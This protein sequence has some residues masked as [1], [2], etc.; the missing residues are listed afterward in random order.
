MMFTPKE[1]QLLNVEKLSLGIQESIFYFPLF[2][3]TQEESE[4]RILYSMLTRYLLE[5]KR[6]SLNPVSSHC[7]VFYFYSS[8]DYKSEL[9]RGRE[10]LNKVVCQLEVVF[11]LHL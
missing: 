7:L 4:I 8:A 10:K 2:S 6:I 9:K 1:F 11:V 5:Y 3:Y